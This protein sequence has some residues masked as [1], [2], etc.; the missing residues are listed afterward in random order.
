[1]DPWEGRA[2][3]NLFRASATC[4]RRAAYKIANGC[5][6]NRPAVRTEF[7]AVLTPTGASDRMRHDAATQSSDT[8]QVTAA[9]CRPRVTS[10]CLYEYFTSGGLWDATHCVDASPTK[11]QASIIAEGRAMASAV[12]ADLAAIDDAEIICLRDARLS[13][14]RPQGCRTIDVGDAEDDAQLL[15][16][17]AA[18]SDWTIVIAPET[19]GA[20]SERCRRVVASGGRLLGPSP[21]LVALASDK[22]RTAVRLA[23]AGMP[24]PLG[25]EHPAGQPWPPDFRYPA[26]WKPLDGA[27]SERIEL[28]SDHQSPSTAAAGRLGRLE[29]FQPGL[30][31]SVSF[32]CGSRW[33][34]ALP[35]CSQ[36]LSGDGHFRYLGGTTPLPATLAARATQ[37][38]ER[39]MS[40]LDG[41]IGYLG[42]DLILGDRDDGADDCLIEINPRLTTSYIGLR[43][44]CQQNLALAML[45]LAHGADAINLTYRP[46]T[47]TFSAAGGLDAKE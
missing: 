18:T 42:V 45:R 19:G 24:V 27:G 23:A 37:L 46:E 7:A 31:A 29:V 36:R 9:S 39:A 30:P 17:S 32:L 20:L 25:I 21:S 22:Q 14:W 10:I 16:E 13:D 12:A 33:R 8:F 43:A 3:R 2:D 34:V 15:S 4:Q 47:I 26:V 35:P 1:M 41:A 11:Q 6:L 40:S 5:I 38:A 44:A 28:I